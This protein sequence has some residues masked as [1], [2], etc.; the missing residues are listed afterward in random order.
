LV[1]NW[2]TMEPLVKRIRDT[3]LC[4]LDTETTGLD[5]AKDHVLFWSLAPDMESRF[6]LDRRML[7]IFEA[8]I[9]GDES[10]SWVM[11]NANFDNCMLANSGVPLLKGPIYCTL[12]MDWLYDE[13]RRR[14]GL[15]ETAMDY[16]GLNMRKF[17]EVFKKK[18]KETYQDALLRMMD[19]EPESA[20]DYASLDAY[21]TLAVFKHLKEE[22]ENERTV[23][24]NTMWDLFKDFEAPYTKVLYK[25]IR[26]GVMLDIGWLEEIREPIVK[27]MRYLERQINKIAGFEVN[28]QSPTQLRSLFFDRL[29]YEPVK[30]TS[31]GKSGNKQPSTDESILNDWAKAG[32]EVS[33]LI[34]QHRALGKVKGTYVDGMIQRCD[35]HLRIHPMLTQSVTVTGRL[36]SREPNLQNIP[37]PDDDKYG[38]RGAFMPGTGMTLVAADYRQLE[39]RILAHVS[40]DKRM[41][42]VI[43]NGWDIH[44]GTAS[45]MYNV[46]YEEMAAAKKKA[47]QLKEAEVPREKWPA[48]V[49]ELMGY[50]QDA[51]AIGFGINYGKGDNAL[52]E[53]LGISKEE[54]QERKR[55]YF[56]PYPNVELFIATTHR[57]TRETLEVA[58][59]LGHKRRLTDADADWRGGY[60]DLRQRRDVPERPGPLAA[61]ALRQDV[62]SIIQGSAANIAKLAQQLCEESEDLARLGAEQ[63]LQVHDEIL[64]EVP[65]EYLKECCETIKGIMEK[66]LIDIPERL[67]YNFR[68]LDVPLDVDVGHGEAWSE[69]H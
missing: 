27:D 34:L 19:Q 50:R 49:R 23:H 22:L 62:N 45:V 17:K 51:K 3:K 32:C 26:R 48:R 33:K 54:A 35:P 36:S 20:I 69:A 7:E 53:D 24:G 67:G 5:L 6:C 63:I 25:C 47:D 13:N 57:Q 52:A 30:M 11:T 61:R 65:E 12:V 44:M 60:Y 21:A 38:L 18:Q 41:Q 55:K 59:I 42:E 58:T 9:A 14:H 1:D 10:I 2:E 31:G 16:L 28:P 29:G 4:G 37:R 40:K 66:P 8:E 43:R 39:M 15:K 68:E 46:P 56:K 64:F